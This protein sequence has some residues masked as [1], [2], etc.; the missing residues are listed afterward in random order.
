[1]QPNAVH[2]DAMDAIS[3]G[4]EGVVMTWEPV[5]ELGSLDQSVYYDIYLDGVKVDTV[6][7]ITRTATS[8]TFADVTEGAHTVGVRAVFMPTETP[9]ELAEVEVNHVLSGISGPDGGLGDV[10]V[11]ASAG[12]VIDRAPEGSVVMICDINGRR[13]AEV[14]V[15]NGCYRFKTSGIVVVSVATAEGRM[16]VKVRVD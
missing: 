7:G 6:D 9:T 1:M 5:V 13:I 11:S 4:E 15:M 8:Y 14:A 2:G 10:S 16:S 3:S 12:E